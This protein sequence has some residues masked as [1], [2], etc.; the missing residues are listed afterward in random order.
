MLSITDCAFSWPISAWQ[1]FASSAFPLCLAVCEA[2]VCLGQTREVERT[3]IVV[4]YISLVVA[5]TV[6]GF[7]NAHGVVRKVDI[8]IIAEEFRH[9]GCRCAKNK[10]GIAKQM[11][12]HSGKIQVD[13]SC[14]QAFGPPALPG[15]RTV[16]LRYY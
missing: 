5:T 15:T 9:C 10:S 1:N 7:P 2:K 14:C 4:E 6:V 8:A 13:R 12:E 3:L 11:E 16:P